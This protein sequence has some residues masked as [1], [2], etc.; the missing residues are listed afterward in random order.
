MEGHPGYGVLGSIVMNPKVVADDGR[1]GENSAQGQ[2]VIRMPPGASL[3]V[4]GNR[5][6]CQT[7]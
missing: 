2:S 5:G 4:H 7:P 3:L 6:R 1:R